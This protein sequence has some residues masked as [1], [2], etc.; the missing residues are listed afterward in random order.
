MF[1]YTH[2]FFKSLPNFIISCVFVVDMFLNV[3]DR[4]KLQQQ[5]QPF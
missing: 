2:R 5:C 4:L 3:W 1:T